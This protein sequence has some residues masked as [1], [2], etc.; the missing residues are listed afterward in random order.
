MCVKMKK[1]T[2][3]KYLLLMIYFCFIS[4]ELFYSQNYCQKNLDY[5]TDLYGFFIEK[6]SPHK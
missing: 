6:N 1:I 5:E 2:K 3:K 4:F